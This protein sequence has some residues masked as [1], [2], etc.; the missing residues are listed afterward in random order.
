MAWCDVRANLARAEAFVAGCDADIVV[1]PETFAT[2]FVVDTEAVAQRMDGTVVTWLKRTAA[3]YDRAIVGSVAI[4]E[5]GKCFNRMLFVKP[6]GEIACY[7]KRHLFGIGGED[8]CFLPGD[9]RVIVEYRGVRFLLLV[10]YD[11][12]FPVWSRNRGD[13]DAIICPA[14]WAASRRNVW[15]TLLRARAIENLAYVVGVNRT[16][17]DPSTKY[18]GDSAVIDFRGETLVEMNDREGLVTAVLD[19]DRLV[20]FRESFPVWRDADNFE[21]K[22]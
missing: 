14:S 2:G 15:R 19:T 7:D 10:C 4:N 8:K 5:N 12:R 11:L 22:P 3:K 16:G 1:L 13:Y 9:K 6:S 20:H 21:I 17:A 18:V